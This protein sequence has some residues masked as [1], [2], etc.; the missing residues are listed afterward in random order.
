MYNTNY[1]RFDFKMIACTGTSQGTL[2]I[3]SISEDKIIGQG[4]KGGFRPVFILSPKVK[5]IGGE[6]TEEIP[7]EIGL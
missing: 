4:N 2:N 7:F 1:S 5:I 3:F 6:G